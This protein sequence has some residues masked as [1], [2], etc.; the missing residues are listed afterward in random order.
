VT[1]SYEI[2]LS[3]IRGASSTQAIL[4]QI[5]KRSPETFSASQVLLTRSVPQIRGNWVSFIR[6]LSSSASR[7]SMSKYE[8][9]GPEVIGCES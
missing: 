4:A 9:V 7:S 1:P 3:K 2:E 5:W 6:E 8:D